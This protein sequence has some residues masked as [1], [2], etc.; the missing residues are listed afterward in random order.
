MKL[1]IEIDDEYYNDI[2][3]SQSVNNYSVLYALDGIR[4]GT[5]LPKGKWNYIKFRVSDGDFT[6]GVE[7][8]CCK[9]VT[10][11]DDFNYC[12]NCGADMRGEENEDSN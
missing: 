2:K 12:P 11:V 3:N 1:V 9:Y 4:N 8:S 5:P 7:C 10:V 6:R